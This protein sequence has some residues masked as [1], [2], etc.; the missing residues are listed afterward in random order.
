MNKHN[1]SLVGF[2]QAAGVVI[3]CELIAGGLWYGNKFLP[4]AP[5]PLGSILILVLLVFS[6]AVTGSIV[7]GYAAYLALNN[8]I[9]NA[10]NLLFY[11]LLY[12]LA[13]IVIIV[14]TLIITR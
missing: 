11:T 5:G 2:L 6:A 10:L 14:M 8:K 4:T 12:C 9:K 3:Y 13:F 7:F 1:L